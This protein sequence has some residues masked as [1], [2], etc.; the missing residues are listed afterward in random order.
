MERIIHIVPTTEGWRLVG[1]HPDGVE[2][3]RV[4]VHHAATAAER[5]RRFDRAVDRYVRVSDRLRRR[6]TRDGVLSL[7]TIDQPSRFRRLADAAWRRFSC[8]LPGDRPED[9]SAR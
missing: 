8:E 2:P 3:V 5:A 9:R 4:E 7:G 6:Y 1:P